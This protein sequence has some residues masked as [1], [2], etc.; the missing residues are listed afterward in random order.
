MFAKVFA[1]TMKASLHRG[2]GRIQSFSNFSMA[3]AFLHERQERAVLRPKL[4]ERVAQGVQ[5]LRIDG[6]GRLGDVFV[7]F[8]KRQEDATKFLPAELVDAGVAREAKKPRLELRRGL[9]TVDRADHFNKDLLGQ[10]FDV[11]APASHGVNKASDPMLIGDDEL[12]LGVF[13]ALLSPANKV[14]QRGR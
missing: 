3:A 12:A 13:V 14:G 5:F 10:I 6:P 9:Q 8:A 2:H 1:G 11:I 7:L 4:S